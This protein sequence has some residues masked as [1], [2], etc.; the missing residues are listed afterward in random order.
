MFAAITDDPVVLI[1]VVLAIIALFIFI[2][3]RR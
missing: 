1:L 2:I 3:R